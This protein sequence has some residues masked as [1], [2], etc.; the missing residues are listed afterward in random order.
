MY[1]HDA[2]V[3]L[4]A[5]DLSSNG[6]GVVAS[7][8]LSDGKAI[9]LA[10]C[11]PRGSYLLTWQRPAKAQDGNDNNGNLKIWDGQSGTLLQSL[12]CKKATLNTLQWTHDESLAFHMVTNEIHIYDMDWKRVG[13]VRCPGVVS[14]SLPSVR[15]Y[16]KN[17]SQQ[18]SEKKY[19]FT[20]FCSHKDKPS[21][22][23]LLRYPDKMGRDSSTVI[24]G[25]TN[26]NNLPSGPSLT[27]KS[28]N[29]EEVQVQ[30]SPR[31]DSALLLTQTAVD[32]TGQ[33]YYGSTHLYL[34]L[35][36]DPKNPTVGKALSVPAPS[37]AKGDGVIPIV[38]ASW[39]SN[40]TI[41]GVVPFTVISGKMPSLSSL[42]HGISGEPMFLLGKAHRNCIDVSPHGRFLVVGGYGNL[43]GGMDFWDR[44][45][46][47]MIPRHAVVE[48]AKTYVTVKESGD[49]T[50]TSPSPV[51]GHEWSPDSRSYM[52][53]TTSP[54]MNVE[55]GV[56]IYRYDGSL[57]EEKMLPWENERYRPDKLL[58]AQYVPAPLVEGG[59]EDAGEFYYYP[60]RAQSPPPR[61]LQE[62]K[63]EAA[64]KAL[65]GI[66]QTAAAKT[67]GTPA[68]ATAYVPPGA[69]GGGGG[70]YVP[71]GARGG[72]GGGSLAERMR[73]EREGSAAALTGKK[74]VKRTGPVGAASVG[75]VGSAPIE[76]AKSKNAIRREKQRLAKEKAERD[77]LEAEQ[78]KKEEE[79]AR[80]EANRNDPEKRAKKIKK[81][82]KQIDEIKEK[83][84]QGTELN[85]DQKKKLDTEEELRKELAALGL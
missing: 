9:Q 30:W 70:A 27:S 57:V 19:L 61:G 10:K 68:V 80:V 39:I 53:C 72:R 29:A 46:E 4:L 52:V 5:A 59:G 8:F 50:L 20:V 51:V 31:A 56:Y 41:T 22:V 24:P 67:R 40:P 47:K 7:P 33:S 76:Y 69:R 25:E 36:S 49:L 48:P 65:A 54:R 21:R 14:F 28:L 45:K 42:H 74:V 16:P 71:P 2:S 66:R 34:L 82:L 79:A 83:A 62:L 58:S 37:E 11:S 81:V 35:E 64:S 15:G 84:A 73:Q 55:N 85:D 32:A 60:D 44:N 1:I 3:G 26:S 43:A 38:S 78:R 63:G 17:A 6:G 13:K 75:P 23:D 77:A 12:H 18:Q